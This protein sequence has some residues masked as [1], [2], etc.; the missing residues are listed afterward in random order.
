MAMPKKLIAFAEQP[1]SVLSDADREFAEAVDRLSRRGVGF[2]FMQQVCEWAWQEYC[3]RMGL[4]A[5]A[6]GPES[7]AAEVARL[8]AENRELR[9][10]V[11]RLES[12]AD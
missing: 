1:G 8:E 10:L 12:R 6:W 2:G 11:R 9:S 5:G 4:P 3:E 7:H